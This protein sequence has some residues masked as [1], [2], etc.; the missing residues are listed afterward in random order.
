MGITPHNAV[1]FRTGDT[2]FNFTSN[3]G[4]NLDITVQQ[5]ITILQ[6]AEVMV[7]VKVIM[8]PDDITLPVHFYEFGSDTTQE[9]SRFSACFLKP[10]VVTIGK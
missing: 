5:E 8:F 2:T 10:K 6:T 9:N 3:L 1:L 7:Q 4:W